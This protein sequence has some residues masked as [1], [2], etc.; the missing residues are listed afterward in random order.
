MAI[1]QQIGSNNSNEAPA[2]VFLDQQF[3]LRSGTHGEVCCYLVYFDH[4]MAIKT[5][6]TTTSLV[7]PS[8]FQ[9]SDGSLD[10]PNAITLSDGT[11]HVEIRL[12][13]GQKANQE[14]HPCIEDVRIDTVLAAC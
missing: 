9:D 8:Q 12:C 10:G 7:T 1:S 6:G 11:T 4:L 3:P 14:L 2:T 13:N 5:D